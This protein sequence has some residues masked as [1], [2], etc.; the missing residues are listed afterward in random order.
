MGKIT[1]KEI[2]IKKLDIRFGVEK[3]EQIA[4]EI[5]SE[6]YE[7]VSATTGGSEKGQLTKLILVFKKKNI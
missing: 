7:L 1:E 6:G 3:A 5:T 4:N 2:I